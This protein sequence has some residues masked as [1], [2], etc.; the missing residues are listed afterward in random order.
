MLSLLGVNAVDLPDVGPLSRDTIRKKYPSR[1]D[2]ESS[3]KSEKVKTKRGLC[4]EI[5]SSPVQ[6]HGA[7]VS[8]KP[9][10]VIR[11]RN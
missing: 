2:Q 6:K 1:E 7:D 9:W 11:S 10:L 8:F 3:E 4:V 5:Q